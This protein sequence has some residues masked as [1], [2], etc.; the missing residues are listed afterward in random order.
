MAYLKSTEIHAFPA[1]YRGA[2]DSG[3]LFDPESALTTE[4]SLR[5]L[6]FGRF[7]KKSGVYLDPATNSLIV[8]VGGYLFEIPGNDPK[9]AIG[10]IVSVSGASGSE[11]AAIYASVRIASLGT[12]VGNGSYDFDQLQSTS[13][14]ETGESLD[15]QEGSDWFFR[16]LAFSTQPEGGTEHVKVLEFTGGAWNIPEAFSFVTDTS[17]VE[18]ADSGLSLQS[19]L[20]TEKVEAQDIYSTEIEAQNISGTEVKGTEVKAQDIYGIDLLITDDG[21]P[22]E[23]NFGSQANLTRRTFVLS[24]DYDADNKTRISASIGDDVTDS[25]KTTWASWGSY[26]GNSSIE[27]N[28]EPSNASIVMEGDDKSTLS[29]GNLTLEDGSSGSSVK[30]N[31]V[32]FI[33]VYEDSASEEPPARNLEIDI[34]ELNANVQGFSVDSA[35]NVSISAGSALSLKGLSLELPSVF[36]GTAI[37]APNSL[38]SLDSS[39]HVVKADL[40]SSMDFFASDNDSVTIADSV[41][42]DSTGKVSISSK[43]E[44]PM[45]DIGKVG[46][47]SHD[48]QR[49]SGLKGFNGGIASRTL[50]FNDD[51]SVD[52][53]FKKI[54]GSD[55]SPVGGAGTSFELFYDVLNGDYLEHWLIT[56]YNPASNAHVVTGITLSVVNTDNTPA[57]YQSVFKYNFGNNTATKF[58]W[59]LTNDAYRMDYRIAESDDI[60][61]LFE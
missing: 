37:D 28:V 59:A 20:T 17:Q 10:K 9:D 27:C 49:V 16:G 33:R 1:S 29:I 21:M 5:F 15:Y 60:S 38:L 25:K 54:F 44:I 52:D 58:N 11:G 18:D 57:D 55:N 43:S 7:S 23:G 40:A 35:G 4:K 26:S 50:Y 22:N 19:S 41:N 45:A 31:T 34:D 61:G 36:E 2:D 8:F 32:E 39:G 24:N 56:L 51:T 12:V 30:R 48:D 47:V 13:S 14:Q 53:V 42:Q 6:S 3:T 46:L